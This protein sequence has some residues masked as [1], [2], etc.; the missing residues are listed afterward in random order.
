V[1]LLVSIF[2]W[3]EVAAG[4][5]VFADALAKHGFGGMGAVFSVV[6][7]SAAVSC[8]NSGLY[9]TSRAVYALSRGGMAPR[10]LSRLSK[11]GVPTNAILISIG[12]CWISILAF[13]MDRSGRLYETLLALSGFTGAV[14]WISI[15]WSQLNFRR[16]LE[17]LGHD[18]RALPFRVPGFPWFTHAAIWLQV[19]ILAAQVFNP[20]LRLS[21]YLS[22]A[23][24]AVPMIWYALWGK[25]LRTESPDARRRRVE[26]AVGRGL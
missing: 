20:G 19:V 16:R 3:R 15:C 10:W 26:Q 21:M 14:A 1:L 7:L 9:A 24:L 17:R 11:D 8:S 12:G 4:R 23:L 22:G 6:V 2:P 13:T 18:A 25:R 5:S